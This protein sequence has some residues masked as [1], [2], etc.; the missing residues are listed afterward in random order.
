MFINTNIVVSKRFSQIRLFLSFFLHSTCR[1]R[2]EKQ[3]ISNFRGKKI[4]FGEQHRKPLNNAKTRKRKS[5]Y[6]AITKKKKSNLYSF[7]YRKNRETTIT[8]QTD[9]CLKRLLSPIIFSLLLHVGIFFCDDL[10]SFSI[11]PP[12]FF[13]HS[14]SR[15]PNR[16]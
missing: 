2:T 6:V 14:K 3:S 5:L 9:F 13:R 8:S 11:N 16:G 12:T 7:G 4:L 10:S 1:R 15:D